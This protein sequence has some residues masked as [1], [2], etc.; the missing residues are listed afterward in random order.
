MKGTTNRTTTPDED[1]F[2]EGMRL[3]PADCPPEPKIAYQSQIPHKT[4]DLTLIDGRTFLASTVSGNICPPGAPDVGFFSHDTRFL[5]QL[6][7]QVGGQATIL[8]SSSSERT[9]AS[10]IEM[11]MKM[12]S[13]ENNLDIPENNIHLRREQVLAGN[14]FFDSLRF[15]NF[16][17]REQQLKIELTLDA[18]FMDI[19][20][21][22]G[23]IRGR[24]GQYFKPLIKPDSMIFLYR[25]L[26]NME[27]TTTVEFAPEPASIQDH[28]VQWDVR[29]PPLTRS[30]L[31]VRITPR[32]RD[33]STSP[34]KDTGESLENTTLVDNGAKLPPI[35]H[36]AYNHLLQ[37]R[38]DTFAGWQ[39]ES[40]FFR[41]SNQV[42]DRL[43]M[44]NISDIHALLIPEGKHHI[45]AA[46]VPWFD[47][48][49]GRDSLIAAYQTLM[50]NP[51]LAA[52]TLRVLARYQG[53]T[54][55]DLR[56]EEPGKILHEHR[57][58]EMSRRCEV[59][60]GHYY[61]SVDATPLYL[62][63]FTSMLEWLGDPQLYIELFPAA[64]AAL[65]W[66]DNYGDLDGDGLIEFKRRSPTGLLNQGW[67]DS[68]DANLFPDGTLA[69]APIA[70]IEVQ[71]Y[72]YAAKRKMAMLMERLGDFEHAGLL[73]KQAGELRARIDQA[74][75]MPER[76]YYAMALDRD[77]RQL[78]VIASN[79]GHLL[80]TGAISQERAEN[81]AQ[82]CMREGLNSGWGIRTLSQ[83][84]RTFNPMSYHRGS[85]W[86]HDNSLIVHGLARSGFKKRAG[87]ICNNLFE[88]ALHFRDYRLPELFC[89]IQRRPYDVP[90]EYPVSCSPQAWASG[91]IF[92]MLSSMLGLHPSAHSR[93][94]Q[95]IDPSLP[96]FL[97]WLHI[98]NL[99]VGN[100]R[101][102]LDF[103]HHEGR[104]F[105]NV[106][107]VQGEPLRVSVTF[108]SKV[109][110][111]LRA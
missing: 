6:E 78:D 84:E 108:D 80:F 58:G 95:I 104:T 91:S 56:D 79:P 20:Q 111:A 19:F 73:K 49:F 110:A 103:S 46:G 75:W 22:R 36:S 43:L 90:V 38:R 82:A 21:V 88:A 32:T 74:F 14:A 42:F 60:F 30:E 10:Q 61:G 89:G 5:S 97:D 69:E 101:V 77:K 17:D 81:V 99:R 41:S 51:Q 27:L 68:G 9:Y 109:A 45:I 72:V 7:L 55:D 70:L 39:K 87:Q 76:N 57:S 100:S 83:K 53:A 35:A 67:K 15:E 28:T 11:T 34:R 107:D 71:G 65:D 31:L 92:L 50:L 24:C 96:P 47:T 3:E 13:E 44:N 62:L 52:D 94:L 4:D 66:I 86:P 106:V 64:Q 54:V 2:Y 48:V 16:T 59:P 25:G 102:S 12:V 93:E 33:L 23:M 40:T 1:L 105:C 37:Q 26:D 8:L 98:R 29:L 85:V 63:V 18:D